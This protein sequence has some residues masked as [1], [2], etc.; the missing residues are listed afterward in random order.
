MGLRLGWL[1]ERVVSVRGVQRLSCGVGGRTDGGGVD[2][3]VELVWQ[4][5]LEER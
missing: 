1:E 3:I 2:L 4:A 5:V